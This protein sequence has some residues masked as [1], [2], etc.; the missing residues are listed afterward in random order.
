M[1]INSNF[2]C[3]R[4]AM[5]SSFGI[6]NAPALTFSSAILPRPSGSSRTALNRQKNQHISPASLYLQ[7]TWKLPRFPGDLT[8]KYL[9]C[10]LLNLPRM[11]HP[12][13]PSS[14]T[15][16]DGSRTT[17]ATNR[18]LWCTSDQ[19]RLTGA[20][21]LWTTR[22]QHLSRPRKPIPCVLSDRR[23]IVRTKWY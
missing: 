1:A 15:P 2:S 13:G 18:K 9:F 5:R 21:K 10:V 14:T 4:L 20:S 11:T 22:L 6:K 7:T 19:R 17:K 23:S 3:S 16:Y 8:R 12:T